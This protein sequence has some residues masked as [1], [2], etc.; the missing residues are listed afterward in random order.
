MRRLFKPFRTH[1]DDIA[2]VAAGIALALTIF[3]GVGWALIYVSL[4][5]VLLGVS[6]L[7]VKSLNIHFIGVCRRIAF[8]SMEGAIAV[9]LAAGGYPYAALLLVACLMLMLYRATVRDQSWYRTA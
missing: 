8:S 1:R 9:L 4:R 7:L 3:F 2:I 5:A 6:L